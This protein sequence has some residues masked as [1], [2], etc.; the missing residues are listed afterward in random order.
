[1]QIQILGRNVMKLTLNNY[2]F[3]KN[4]ETIKLL[5]SSLTLLL[6]ILIF[7]LSGC[8]Q[9]T[10]SE[11]A[12]FKSQNENKM[13]DDELERNHHLWRE[14]KI[15]NYNFESTKYQGGQYVWVPVS[16]QVRNDSA[17]SMQPVRERL[18]LEKID[19]YEDFDTVEKIFDQ[20][21]VR[22][23]SGDKVIV[24]YNKEFGYP[25]KTRIQ[26]RNGGADTDFTIEI[27]KFEVIKTN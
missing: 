10:K 23:R 20:I 8:G 19:G 4:K 21:Q 7:Q 1:M 24:T 27:S 14:S 2:R 22:R 5:N 3:L 13:T 9:S 16:I 11:V 12:D 6:L 15:V 25:E 18:P 26:P 17:I